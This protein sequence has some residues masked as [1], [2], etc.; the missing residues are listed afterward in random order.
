MSIENRTDHDP[1]TTTNPEDGRTI[2]VRLT[3]AEYATLVGRASANH[4][5]VAGQVRHDLATTTAGT[6]VPA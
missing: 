5:T 6:E 1:K 2:H 3:D 4:R